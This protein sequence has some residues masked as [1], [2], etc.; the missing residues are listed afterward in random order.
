MAARPSRKRGT[1]IQS[2]ASSAAACAPRCAPAL[3]WRNPRAGGRRAGV[4]HLQLHP[5]GA[6]GLRRRAEQRA[7]A[8]AKL[9]LH[10]RQQRAEL[11]LLRRRR[12]LPVSLRLNTLLRR[13]A[14]QRAVCCVVDR[15]KAIRTEG[16][17]PLTGLRRPR[18]HPR[19]AR[20]L[21]H[22]VAVVR[23]G[24]LGFGRIAVS[25]TEVPILLA[26]MA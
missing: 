17:C 13:I 5:L 8:A 25:E 21:L 4:N 10:V 22:A 12:R 6:P 2:A 19:P 18:R 15:G 9:P 11:V 23:A 14:V 26:N 16:K 24:R 7:R 20:V 1:S 3:S